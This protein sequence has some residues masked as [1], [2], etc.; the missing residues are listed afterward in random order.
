MQLLQKYCVQRLQR[1][2]WPITISTEQA[3]T[4]LKQAAEA[5]KDQSLYYKIK[6]LDLIAKEFKY[7][8]PCY[9]EFTPKIRQV[10][11]PNPKEPH[12]AGDFVSVVECINVKVLC[13]NQAVSMK[14]YFWALS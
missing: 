10:N 9:R 13:E 12:P 3:V 2:F 1:N 14:S 5:S 7:H 6:D 8:E 4:T 11:L